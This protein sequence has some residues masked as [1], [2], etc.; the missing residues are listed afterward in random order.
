MGFESA[1]VL[2]T[3]ATGAL[4]QEFVAAFLREGAARVY[5][6][7]D[8]GRDWAD[9]RVVP[10]EFDE[11]R[12]ADIRRL[13]DI[14]TDVTVVVRSIAPEPLPVPILAI[15]DESVG[16]ML[17]EHAL[18]AVRLARA[19]GPAIARNGGGVFAVVQ[20]V[21]AWISANGAYAPGQAALWSVTNALRVELRYAG[22]HVLGVVLG[23]VMSEA[24]G[25]RA[26]PRTDPGLV[27]GLTLEAIS[28][29]KYELLVDEYSRIVKSRLAEGLQVMYPELG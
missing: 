24:T 17:S 28:A 12:P 5:A 21:Q 22:I 19:L 11:R 15:D 13:R 16:D 3:R 26:H 9:A 8:G 1:V 7:G 6:A 18:G 27:V 4:G 20:S 29:R 23:L 10:L 14:A 2:V 25:D